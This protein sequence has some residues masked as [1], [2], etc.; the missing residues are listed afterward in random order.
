MDNNFYY[1]DIAAS[2][3]KLGDTFQFNTRKN[4]KRYTIKPVADGRNPEEIGGEGWRGSVP[5]DQKG[6]L[7]IIVQNCGQLVLAKDC[8][9]VLVAPIP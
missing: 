1:K 4:G 7:L 8:R 6:K 2:E 9:V 3:L 5:E